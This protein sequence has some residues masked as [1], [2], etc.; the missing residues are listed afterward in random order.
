MRPQC[1]IARVWVAVE[2]WLNPTLRLTTPERALYYHLVRVTHLLG[3]RTAYVSRRRMAAITGLSTATARLYLR[4]LA[5]KRCI[6]FVSRG[7]RGTRVEVYLPD[8][9]ARRWARLPRAERLAFAPQSP[10]RDAA[11]QPRAWQRT[12]PIYTFE[13]R[14]RILRREAGRCFYCLRRLQRNEWTLDHVVPLARGG[15]DRADNLV[16]CC[17]VC[18]WSKGLL[19]A[20]DFL[21]QLVRKKILS[22]S[23][24]RGRLRALARLGKRHQDEGP[25]W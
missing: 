20:E 16:A 14:S 11:G 4:L 17:A 25:A 21:H 9:I 7:R 10:A 18:N 15:S 3:H 6:R 24:L 8:E 23:R 13:F 22:R 2:D 12:D 19:T 5:R 1:Q